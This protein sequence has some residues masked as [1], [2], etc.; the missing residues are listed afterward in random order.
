VIR[1][2]VAGLFLLRCSSI[3]AQ[4]APSELTDDARHSFEEGMAAEKRAA[5]KDARKSFL[6]AVGIQEHPAIYYNLGFVEAQAGHEPAA[7]AWLDVFL[8]AVPDTP[9]AES[10]R[11]EVKRLK[12]SCKEKVLTLVKEAGDI[13]PSNRG[14]EVENSAA[15]LW[16]YTGFVDEPQAVGYLLQVDDVTDAKVFLDKH[17]PDDGDSEFSIKQFDDAVREVVR[18]LAKK[19][20]FTEAK[21]Y[22]ATT[23]SADGKEQTDAIL[24]AASELKDYPTRLRS[25]SPDSVSDATLNRLLE[26]Y[27]SQ[28]GQVFQEIFQMLLDSG[29]FVAARSWAARPKWKSRLD[30]GNNLRFAALCALRTG[31]RRLAKDIAREILEMHNDESKHPEVAVGVASEDQAVSLVI[32]GEYNRAMSLLDYEVRF[33]MLPFHFSYSTQFDGYSTYF[34]SVLG[35]YELLATC[36]F[37]AAMARDYDQ[38]LQ[39]AHIAKTKL[40]HGQYLATS[41]IAYALIL[42]QKWDAAK[43][44]ID[45]LP[46][47]AEEDFQPFIWKTQ[48][49]GQIIS[50]QIGQGKLAEAE[51]FFRDI[52]TP[53]EWKDG[54]PTGVA[55]RIRALLALAKGYQNRPRGISNQAASAGA[56]RCINEASSTIRNYLRN[57]HYQEKDPAHLYG[58]EEAVNA[59]KAR[60]VGPGAVASSSLPPKKLRTWINLAMEFSTDELLSVEPEKYLKEI[61]EAP[62]HSIA[63]SLGAWAKK[64]GDGLLRIEMA[65]RAANSDSQEK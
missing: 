47:N 62:A 15:V 36:A 12:A 10:I 17:R 21:R 13:D 4:E 5:W 42:Q 24:K 51:A 34:S 63:P 26:K 30:R 1:A 18:Y 23:I 2:F 32:L 57:A 46:L 48:L 8:M 19:G 52:P 45:G 3:F 43:R 11:D 50:Q 40:S 6:T 28:D 64:Y 58:L 37:A 29:N 33:D 53:E 27:G 59:A 44:V 7:I 54:W 35:K 65:E 14:D 31:D 56:V 25:R 9:N 41:H 61:R 16:G 49:L 39:F 38:A 22:A 60:I 55:F 20:D